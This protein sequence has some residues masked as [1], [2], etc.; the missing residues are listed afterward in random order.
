MTAQQELLTKRWHG[1]FQHIHV[2]SAALIQFSNRFWAI[3]PYVTKQHANPCLETAK[4]KPNAMLQSSMQPHVLKQHS[5]SQMQR[6]LRMQHSSTAL[7]SAHMARSCSSL[8]Q[9]STELCHT[10]MMP[11]LNMRWVRAA[12][13]VTLCARMLLSY[14]NGLSPCYLT[15]VCCQLNYS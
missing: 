3:P 4:S 11:V 12:E 13:E 15:S 7:C 9:D 8:S 1:R 14:A 10:G 5:Y 6:L 2:L